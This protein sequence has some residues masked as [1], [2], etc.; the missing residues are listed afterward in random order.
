MQ[1]YLTLTLTV[2]DDYTILDDYRRQM[3]LDKVIDT[4]REEAIRRGFTVAVEIQS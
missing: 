2:P 3:W 4:A 1:T